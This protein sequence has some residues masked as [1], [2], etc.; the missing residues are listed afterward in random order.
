MG[1]TDSIYLQGNIIDV[2][3]E[4]CKTELLQNIKY[5]CSNDGSKEYF[6]DPISQ[7]KLL[8]L[9]NKYVSKFG[10]GLY[11]FKSETGKSSNCFKLVENG[12]VA[13]VSHLFIRWEDGRTILIYDESE[14]LYRSILENLKSRTK[15]LMVRVGDEF[16]MFSSLN[17]DKLLPIKDVAP[18]NSN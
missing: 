12:L 10:G 1:I 14:S 4:F 2:T 9:N 18:D 16:V 8:D 6:K 3:F 11:H 17:I 15:D 7:R 13:K 5:E